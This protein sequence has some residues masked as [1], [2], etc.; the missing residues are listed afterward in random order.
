MQTNDFEIDADTMMLVS[1]AGVIMNAIMAA[2]LHGSLPCMPKMSGGGGHC[3][4]HAP[5]V[6]VH[7][8]NREQLTAGGN[9][10]RVET[11]INVRAAMVHVFG[12][13][14]QSI[15]VLISA[16]VIKNDPSLK[17]ADPICTFIFSAL[18]LTTTIGIMRDACAVLMEVGSIRKCLVVIVECTLHLQQTVR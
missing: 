18:V 13:L 15:G 12:D 9:G 11:N 7:G 17:L 16:Y 8:V 3:H 10:A 2:I 5:A 14:L 4:S 1:A 6:T